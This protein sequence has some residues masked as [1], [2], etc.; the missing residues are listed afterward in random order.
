MEVLKTR[1]WKLVTAVSEHNVDAAKAFYLYDSIQ[2]A[3]CHICFYR[4]RDIFK[5]R[6]NPSINRRVIACCYL[7]NLVCGKER[8]SVASIV[9][10][11][12][13]VGKNYIANA[14]N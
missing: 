13:N 6:A 7:Y 12:F 1:V 3:L 5:V 11:P 8:L 4:N 14:S 2:I 9:N 10:N